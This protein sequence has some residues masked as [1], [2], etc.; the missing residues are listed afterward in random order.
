MNNRKFKAGLK[1]SREEFYKRLERK[2]N[3]RVMANAHVEI[4]KLEFYFE[5]NLTYCNVFYE[6]DEPG[7]PWGGGWKT[8]VFPASESA[9]D[10]LQKY[11]SDYIMWNSGR[12]SMVN[13]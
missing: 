13:E 11:I 3:I 7:T 4:K 8:K 10:I 1:K 9:V 2:L 5:E 6:S 12:Y